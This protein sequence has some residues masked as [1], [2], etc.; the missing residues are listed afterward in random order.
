MGETVSDYCAIDVPFHVALETDSE[1]GHIS[2]YC[3]ELPSVVAAAES[4][5]EFETLITE[6]I[7]FHIEGLARESDND[8]VEK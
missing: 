8:K 3:V 1:T 2:G 7:K 4:W 6:A 5:D